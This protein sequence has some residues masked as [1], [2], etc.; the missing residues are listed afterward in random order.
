VSNAIQRVGL[1]D[2]LL[3]KERDV[4]AARVRHLES[5]LT[6]RSSLQSEAMRMG[7]RQGRVELAEEILASESWD[8]VREYLLEIVEEDGDD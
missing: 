1:Y 6:Q 2:I 4:L 8:T 7:Q 5:I 3:K